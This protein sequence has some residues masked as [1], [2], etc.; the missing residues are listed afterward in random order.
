METLQEERRAFDARSES[1]A[2]VCVVR[3]RTH[4]LR[5][6]NDLYGMPTGNAL[7]GAIQ[8][9]LRTV[10]ADDALHWHQWS[11]FVVVPNDDGDGALFTRAHAVAEDAMDRVAGTY[12]IGVAHR[13]EEL[14]DCEVSVA[15]GIA[16]G[17][18]PEAWATAEVRNQWAHNHYANRMVDADPPN[19]FL[20]SELV[21]RADYALRRKDEDRWLWLMRAATESGISGDRRGGYGLAVRA[22]R[23]GLNSRGENARVALATLV[24][25]MAAQGHIPSP[26]DL[27]PN[28]DA[29]IETYARS[30]PSRQ[31]E[32]ELNDLL[33]VVTLAEVAE[34]WL[35]H[36]RKRAKWRSRP[37]VIPYSWARKVW[38]NDAL[39]NDERMLR[40]GVLELV[41]AAQTDQELGEIAAV[42]MEYVV[43]DDEDRLRWI[44]AQARQSEK[45]RRCLADLFVWHDHSG[46]VAARVEAA[47]GLRLPRPPLEWT[48]HRA[49]IASRLALEEVGHSSGVRQECL[50]SACRGGFNYVP[51]GLERSVAFCE[52]CLQRH[53]WSPEQVRWR[54]DQAVTDDPS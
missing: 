40:E 32:A 34:A 36:T 42:V 19:D 28:G 53:D 22:G 48:T 7:L 9:R 47:A 45:F 13:P 18:F 33:S 43:T 54:I 14:V 3:V 30:A 37:G 8:H 20:M 11:A 38:D 51:D 31:G 41:A 6:V 27:L 24:L 1:F 29:V 35:R 49:R 5:T 44:E 25:T 12:T 4:G 23:D 50:I 46:R 16:I 2:E 15:I 10:P 21:L 52:M 26:S 39:W 17:P